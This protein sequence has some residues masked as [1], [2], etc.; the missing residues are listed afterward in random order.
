MTEIS[1]TRATFVLVLIA[2]C[3][4]GMIIEVLWSNRR[5]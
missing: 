4:A 5:K 1:D 3:V 2:L